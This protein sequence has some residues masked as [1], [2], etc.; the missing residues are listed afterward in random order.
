MTYPPPSD[1]RR[2]APR[3]SFAELTP[4][5]LRCKNG[6]RVSGKLQVI[7]LTGGLLCL[8]RP[9]DQGSQVKLMFLTGKGS[10]LGAAEMLSPISWS[11]QPFKFVALYDDDQGK[12][13]A[14]IQSS[15]KQNR[16]DHGQ[17]ERHRAW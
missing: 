13:Q 17:M 6:R 7:S 2:R 10:V 8:P 3:T 11:L 9:L 1:A 16:Q 15:L 14:A 5:V 12:L 4:A